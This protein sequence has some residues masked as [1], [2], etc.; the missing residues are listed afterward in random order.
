MSVSRNVGFYPGW[1]VLA[2]SFLCASLSV[3]FTSYVFGLF[4]LPVTEE[5]GISRA[6][7]NNG[8]IS[9]MIGSMIMAPLVGTLLDRL[10]ARLLMTLG[11]LAFVVAS[12]IISK[13]QSLAVIVAT[14]FLLVSFSVATLGP[15][16]ANTIVV[17][18]FKR[19]RG[20][21]LGILAISTSAGGFMAQPVTAHLI[22]NY[23]WRSA[24]MMTGIGAACIFLLLITF[25]VRTRPTGAESGHAEEFGLV[26]RDGAEPATERTWTNKDLFRSRNFWLLSVGAALFFGTEQA[27]MVS[28]ASYLQDI[29]FDLATA[30]LVISVKTLSAACGKFVIGFFADKVDLRILYAFVCGANV[31][32][33]S[34]FIMQP[35]LPVLL[36][37]VAVFG[38]A[39]GGITAVWT[40][41]IA[42]LFGGLSYGKILGFGMVAQ[43]ICAIIALRLVGMTYDI[44]GSYVP[45]FGAI[46]VTNLISLSLIWMLRPRA[47]V[48]DLPAAVTA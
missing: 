24:V 46:I 45:A 25:V 34:A 13:A 26:V 37:F 29:G 4:L 18:W 39:V 15:L 5:F 40:M 44:T 1:Q 12:F 6:S 8:V 41:L 14:L 42:W 33:M 16:G 35:S 48:Q 28:T 20:R 36:G 21:A 19:R 10:P 27:I 32:L 2:G 9:M 17:R 23:G 31:I 38:V 30:A 22:A 7:F 43:Q 47:Q 3:G 11:T